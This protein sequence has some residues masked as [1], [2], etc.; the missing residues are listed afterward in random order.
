V[1]YRIVTAQAN[2]D[3]TVDLVWSNGEAARVDF[4]PIIGK[5]GVLAPLKDAAFFCEQ[6]AITQDG[7]ALEW[8]DALDFS[9][10]SLLYRAFPELQKADGGS[11]SAAE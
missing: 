6:M 4:K 3:H 2:D 9:A 5:G 1:R 7:R 11:Q 10:D 8:P